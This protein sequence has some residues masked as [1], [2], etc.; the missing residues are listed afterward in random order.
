MTDEAIIIRTLG[1]VRA[2]A[3]QAERR[4]GLPPAVLRGDDA[5]VELRSVPRP[6]PHAP[7]RGGN[8]HPVPR[9]NPA[10]SGGRRME[11]HF[12]VWDEAPQAGQGAVLTLAKQAGRG[13]KK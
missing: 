7:V 12:R 13:N 5:R 2:I 11:F 3:G 6:R 1:V 4:T 8:H 9:L 10:L